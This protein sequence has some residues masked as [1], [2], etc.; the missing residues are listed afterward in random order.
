MAIGI[1]MGAFDAVGLKPD[2]GA[3]VAGVTLS[4]HRRAPELARRLLEFKDILLIGFFL[5]IGLGGAPGPAAIGVAAIVLLLVPL[6]TAGYLLVLTRFRLR[7]RT[8]WHTSVTLANFSEFGLIVAAVAVGRGVLDQQWSAAIAIAVAVSFALA[9]P[10]STARYSL[11]RR[12]SPRLAR[13]ERQPIRAQDTLIGSVG[14]RTLVFGMGRIGTGAFDEL[15]ARR[16]ASVMGVDRHDEVVEE[17]TA[18]GRRTVR[19][20]ALDADFWDRV[21]LN[22]EIDLVVLSMSDH[23]ANLE[24]VRRVKTFLPRARIAATAAHPDEVAEL[25]DAGV[26]VARNLYGEAGQGLADDACDLLGPTDR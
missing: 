25:R 16:G 20:D 26:D 19:G 18:A 21:H 13:L 23:Q 7:A 8:S 5:S 24:A 10:V 3:L 2:L 9:A 6:K 1:G 11:Y 15:V 12:W 22:D 4:G 14:A 17:H